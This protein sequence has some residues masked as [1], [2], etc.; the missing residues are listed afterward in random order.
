MIERYLC[1]ILKDISIERLL[2]L[3]EDNNMYVTIDN[4][5][6]SSVGFYDEILKERA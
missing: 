5:A 3:L 1:D 4:G 6:I 2:I